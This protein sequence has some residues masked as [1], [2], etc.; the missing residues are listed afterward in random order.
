MS[1][2]PE[3]EPLTPAQK[4]SAVKRLYQAELM[5]KAHVVGV[6][7]GYKQQDGL[8]TD[9]IA[10][11]VMVTQKLP[12]ELLAPED[13]LPEELDGVPVDVQVVGALRAWS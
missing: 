11:V 13:V 7:V 6:G 9:T 2:Q 4:A 8:R 10:V 12:P 3:T 1:S 5:A